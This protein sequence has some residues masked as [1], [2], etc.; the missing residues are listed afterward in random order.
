MLRLKEILHHRTMFS[1]E[2]GQSVVEVAQQMAARNI[3]AILVLENGELRGVFSERDLMKRVVVEGLDPANTPVESVMSTDLTKA[4]ED[5]TAEHAL[6]LMRRGNCRHLPVMR[7]D[8]VVGFISMRDLMISELEW[9][10]EE[11]QHM[12]DYIQSA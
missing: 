10:T 12:R 9:K 1:A 6:E 3:G 11:L 4:D 7:G 5:S 8:Q 2:P